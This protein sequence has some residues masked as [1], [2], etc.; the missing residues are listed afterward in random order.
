MY[1][2]Y[3]AAFPA[4]SDSKSH[5]S[6]KISQLPGDVAWAA[7]AQKV[8]VTDPT[9]AGDEQRSVSLTRCPS[10]GGYGFFYKPIGDEHVRKDPVK[11]ELSTEEL[12][13]TEELFR[14]YVGRR[15]AGRFERVLS[16]AEKHDIDQV[17]WSTLLLYF[18]YDTYNTLVKLF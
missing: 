8:P 16:E 11:C 5:S 9:D 18:K 14:A 6:L 7:V 13:Q 2:R 4:L 12:R 15:F 1:F 10:K 3:Y 17:C